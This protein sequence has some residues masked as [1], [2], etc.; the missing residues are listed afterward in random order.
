MDSRKWRHENGTDSFLG[1]KLDVGVIEIRAMLQ[2]RHDEIRAHLSLTL[3][4]SSSVCEGIMH[5]A[6]NMSRNFY[7]VSARPRHERNLMSPYFA[8]NRGDCV[9]E[10]KRSFW[11]PGGGPRLEHLR[12]G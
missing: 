6:P 7:A 4:G 11:I 9:A 10:S 1:C 3:A 5:A 12:L 2:R 8:A